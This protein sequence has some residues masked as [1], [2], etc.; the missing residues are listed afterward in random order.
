MTF[1]TFLSEVLGFAYELRG[2]KFF[3]NCH[4]NLI[5]EPNLFSK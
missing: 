2:F 3:W 5:G 1:K 4:W